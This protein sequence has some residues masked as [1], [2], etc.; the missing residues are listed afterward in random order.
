V[1][2]F[3]LILCVIFSNLNVFK[4]V[5]PLPDVKCHLELLK[6][7]EKPLTKHQL[8]AITLL[9]NSFTVPESGMYCSDWSFT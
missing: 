8:E 6:S 1:N 7:M 4:G 3:M 5:I 2:A 9:E